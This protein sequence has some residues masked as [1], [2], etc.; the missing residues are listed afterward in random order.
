ML[1]LSRTPTIFSLDWRRCQCVASK[2]HERYASAS[3]EQA[4]GGRIAAGRGGR[5]SQSQDDDDSARVAGIV[6]RSKTGR[7]SAW[8]AS[9]ELDK[10][11]LFAL[12]NDGELADADLHANQITRPDVEFIFKTFRFALN[13]IKDDATM[14][15]AKL[16]FSAKKE[17]AKRASAT[18]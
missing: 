11:K 10:W 7:F 2:S 8:V 14:K 15:R 1:K 17:Q 12:Y 13:T 16:H 5:A 4:N 3:R 18:P 6:A 9:K